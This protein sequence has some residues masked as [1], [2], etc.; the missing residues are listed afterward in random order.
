MLT[1]NPFSHECKMP[2][3]KAKLRGFATLSTM[4]RL[5]LLTAFGLVPQSDPGLTSTK[6]ASEE[7]VLSKVAASETARELNFPS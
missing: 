6:I 7:I 4:P 2:N 5:G 3:S 1:Q